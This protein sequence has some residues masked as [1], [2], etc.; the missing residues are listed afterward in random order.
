MTMQQ[1]GPPPAEGSERVPLATLPGPQPEGPRPPS[2]E[3]V[4][5][6][7]IGGLLV[8]A[9]MALCFGLGFGTRLATEPSNST[10]QA[11]AQTAP[12][13]PNF[14]VLNEIYSDIKSQYVD[15]NNL[16]A[17]ALRQGA[18]DG[19]I[20]AVGDAHMGY[21]TQAEYLAETDD[22][23]G[24]F[25]GIGATVE[26]SNGQLSLTPLSPQTPAAKAGL[27]AGD[28]LLTVDGA[29][30]KGWTDL[31]AVQKIRG[32]K[33]TQVT[34]GVKHQNGQQQDLTITRDNI[35]LP[36]VETT[37]LHDAN[38][39]PVNDIAYVKI[40]QFSVR[41]PQELQTQLTSI[42]ANKNYKGLI[43]DLR[44]NPGG[45]VDSVIQ[46]AGDFVN[47]DPVLLVQQKDGSDQTIRPQ[48]N[49]ILTQM[50][51]AVLV[52]HNSASAA[53]ILSG[54]LRADRH[55]KL[56]GETTFGK[57]T[58]NIFVPLKTD[59]GAISITVGRWLTPDHQS[60]DGTGLKPDIAITAANNQDPN[61]TFNDVLYRA[62][63]FLHTGS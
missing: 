30:T 35:D 29:S 40:D 55:A 33:G 53:E 12:G 45:V 6:W 23:S 22:T 38:G 58:E 46:V 7:G 11:T 16:D 49:G 48:N 20:K 28:I 51:L 9:I 61:A 25:S 3:A 41:T 57:G 31:Q 13:S 39:N 34:I 10:K 36:S 59:S 56:I 24:A 47:H 37:A 32:Q 17:S 60:I 44:N 54:A 43:I 1:G 21:L 27:Q 50:P 4:A 19:L 62:I 26:Q 18:I 2:L 63:T 14:D 52:N 15:A 8:V 5:K 42:A